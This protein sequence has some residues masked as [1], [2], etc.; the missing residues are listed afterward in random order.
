MQKACKPR[1]KT[2][3]LHPQKSPPYEKDRKNAEVKLEVSSKQDPKNSRESKTNPIRSHEIGKQ[4]K[5]KDFRVHLIAKLENG[6]K[7]N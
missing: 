6:W 1:N 3:R 5:S 7:N 4:N 2:K